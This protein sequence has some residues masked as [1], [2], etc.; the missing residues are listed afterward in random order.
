MATTNTS[1][2]RLGPVATLAP[3][4]P[5]AIALIHGALISGPGS[6][7]PANPNEEELVTTTVTCQEPIEGFEA[8]HS[9][10]PAGCSLGGAYDP[11][12]NLLKN[13]TVFQGA[14]PAKYFSSENDFAA[15]EKEIPADLGKSNHVD[16]KDALNKAGE[17]QLHG[18]IG[19][20]YDAK[21]E[22]KESSNCELPRD[23][24]E[25]DVDFHI[26]VGF[27]SATAQNLRNKGAVTPDEK[28]K[29]AIVEM[30]PHTRA[31]HPGWTTAALTA[32][33]GRKVRVVGQLM[34]DN[35]HNVS[36]QNCG[37][38]PHTAA[39]W[40]LSVWE[41]HPVT[42]FQVCMD[43]SD[44]SCTETS[45]NWVDLGAEP[46]KAGASTPPKKTTKTKPS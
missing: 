39:C 18:V 12:L 25:Q 34:V 26:W 3:A 19:Y 44:A 4:V 46:P 43:A 31:N 10:Y 27:D 5:L 33:K 37:H 29:A 7:P 16:A 38:N 22:D 6:K 2:K 24:Q 9:Q 21:A 28:K 32:V 11:Y 13:Q 45:T 41:L 35:E 1:R 42:Q 17:G 36:S 40:R 20:L 14:Q 30:T 23:T 8:C 15:L